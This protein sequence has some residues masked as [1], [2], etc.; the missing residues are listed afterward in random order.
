[1]QA[2]VAGTQR[3]ASGEFDRPVEVNRR[4][5]FGQLA[6]AFNDMSRGLI[7]RDALRD[8][9][10]KIERDLSLARKIQQDVLPKHIPACPGYDL[11]AY[12]LPAEGK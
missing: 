5:E 3:I 2:L 9:R 8:E 7:E 4:D 6:G 10:T 11:A 12:S 1:M